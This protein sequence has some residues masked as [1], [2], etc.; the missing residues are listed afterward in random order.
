MRR[1]RA[2]DGISVGSALARAIVLALLW[3]SGSRGAVLAQEGASEVRLGLA[4]VDLMDL[5]LRRRPDGPPEAHA[6]VDAGH[7]ADRYRLARASGAG[8]NRWTLY[9]DLVETGSPYDWTVP[10]GIIGRDRAH[11]LRSLL[12]LQSQAENIEAP[13][14]LDPNGSPTDD[15]GRAA[16]V[17][18]GHVLA[19]FVDAA[20]A[21]YGRGGTVGGAAAWEIGN[22]PNIHPYWRD[23]PEDF[24]RYL[25]V[26]YLTI[27]RRDPAAVVLHGSMAD[28]VAAEDWFRRFL[29]AL[30]QRAADGPQPWAA[31]HFFDKTGWHWYR[32]PAHLQTGPARARAIL[33]E[34]GLPPKPV[35]VTETGVPVW[36]EHPGPCWDSASPG[37][38]TTEEQA[39]FVWQTLAEA[40]A[41]GVELVILFQLYDD[42]GNGPKSYD[43]FGLVRNPLGS[44]CWEGAAAACWRADPALAGRPRPAYQ[45]FALAARLLAGARYL[46]QSPAAGRGWRSVVFQAG[47]RRSTVLWSTGGATSAVVPAAAAQARLHRVTA[48]GV[49]SLALGARDGAFTVPLP[50]VSNHNGMGGRPIMAGVPVILEELGV[51]GSGGTAGE[52]PAAEGAEGPSDA[53][54][55]DPADDLDPPVLAVVEPL[56]ERSP[57]GDL[58]LAVVAGDAGSGLAAWILYV[59]EGEDPPLR[60]EDWRPVE[61]LRPWTAAPAA[62]RVSATLR[63]EPGRRYHFAAQAGDR[64]GN[65]TPLPPYS[66]ASTRT[67]LTGRG[68]AMPASSAARTAPARP[69]DRPDRPFIPFD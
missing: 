43:A 14:F 3:A 33:A 59:A 22:E 42:C 28:D 55:A 16:Q 40:Y 7:L 27:K 54:A 51:A 62:G 48:T 34:A 12:I 53:G 39:G 24:A 10:D 29:V 25:E 61:G 18:P 19:R 11:G 63:L 4:H 15:P 26:A 30:K 65:W 32:S 23:R 41:S 64:A 31:S 8:W 5:H 13:I 21:R 37:R 9:R 57:A 45:A 6:S 67:V 58:S 68:P 1:P 66:Q 49:E 69:R 56:P 20:A 46:R 52:G 36:N 47:D 17:N 50:A 38:A 2:A 44:A 60:P 35:W